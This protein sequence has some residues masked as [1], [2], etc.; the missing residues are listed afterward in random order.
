MHGAALPCLR[1]TMPRS[2]RCKAH[3]RRG[4]PCQRWAIAGGVVCPTH[5]GSTTHIREAAQ[6]R[7]EALILPA[8][9]TLRRLVESSDTDGVSL[10]AAKDILDRCGFKPTDKLEQVTAIQIHVSYEDHPL[11]QMRPDTRQNGQQAL[12]GR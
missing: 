2:Q 4:T 8:I 10:A 5:G 6:R 9:A 3:N 7:L 12:H 11:P 1:S